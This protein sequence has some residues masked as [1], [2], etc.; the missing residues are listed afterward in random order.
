MY[1]HTRMS[2]KKSTKYFTNVS[3]PLFRC[4]FINSALVQQFLTI[5]LYP[6]GC[7]WRWRKMEKMRF[8]SNQW[9]FFIL[10]EGWVLSFTIVK[11]LT[12]S[13]VSEE[14]KYKIQEFKDSNF[15]LTHSCIR[16]FRFFFYILTSGSLTSSQCFGCSAVC[17][18]KKSVWNGFL[19]FPQF[20]S[21]SFV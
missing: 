12:E 14:Q 11:K 16:W 9:F 3:F 20:W 13:R 15:L 10:F 4:F 6:S 2:R 17:G 5:S 18:G 19:H 21:L 7:G 8:H 1:I